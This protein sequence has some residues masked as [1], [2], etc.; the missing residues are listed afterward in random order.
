MVKR[1]KSGGGF[2]PTARQEPEKRGYKT[3]FEKVVE[4]ANGEEKTLMWYQT[5]L[6]NISSDFKIIPGERRDENDIKENQD[7]NVLRQIPLPGHLYFFK[8]EAKM[9]WLPYYDKFPLVYVFKTFGND[10]FYGANLHYVSPK[11]RI[12][13][14]NLLNNN[15]VD[16][17]KGII[18][19][20]INDHV[21]SLFLDL[22]SIEWETSI[23]LP[24]EDFVTT[25]GS[26]KIPYKRT[27]VWKEN[28]KNI[29]DRIKGQRV[30]KRYPDE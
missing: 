9:K 14:I 25:K 21:K 18:H 28:D 23:L 10:H 7:E 16:V 1:K 29:S 5:T 15:I 3:I 6:G 2:Q 24:V 19:K 27:D 12:K 11:H 13:V 17:P 4:K 30:Y 20:Y 26:G 22:A 8:Y